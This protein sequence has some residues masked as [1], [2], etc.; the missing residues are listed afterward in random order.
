VGSATANDRAAWV[1]N[2][3]PFLIEDT[4]RL[5]SQG[6]S[7][8]TNRRYARDFDK[9]ERT[10]SQGSTICREDHTDAARFWMDGPLIWTE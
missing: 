5:G 1:N 2:V 4:G 3:T 7:P 8:R 10:G 6:P 9:V